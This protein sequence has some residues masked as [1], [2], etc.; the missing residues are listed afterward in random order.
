M[1]ILKNNIKTIR[2]YLSSLFSNARSENVEVHQRNYTPEEI[3][4]ISWV[5]SCNYS[6]NFMHISFDDI[7]S[8]LAELFS[9]RHTSIYSVQFFKD[10]KELHDKFGACFSLYVFSDKLDNVTDSYKTEFQQAKDWLRFNF[11]AYKNKKYGRRSIKVDYDRGIEQL[12]VMVGGDADCLDSQIRASYW[13]MSLRNGLY[14]KNHPGHAS[15]IF[16]AKDPFSPAKANYYLTKEQERQIYYN[17]IYLDVRNRIIFIQTCA[18]L[19]T[20]EYCNKSM[21]L[22]AENIKWQK[23]C[24]ILNHEWGYNR[25]RMERF[26]QWAKYEM[27]FRFGFF[28][29]IYSMKTS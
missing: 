26:L 20:D 19:D 21:G 15:Y 5:E 8:C 29:D 1:M 4:F 22:I 3:E 25:E 18:R 23:H 14:I 13:E 9:K 6:G 12:L 27:N 2:T 24:E 28:E 10:L 17:G 11:H 7:S 16:C